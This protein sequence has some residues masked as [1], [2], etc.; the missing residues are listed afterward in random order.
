ME[1]FLI[2]YEKSKTQNP[3]NR[4]ISRKERKEKMINSLKDPNNPYSNVWTN[5]ILKINY[6]VSME[7]KGF[8]NGI[9]LFRIKK[10]KEEPKI[11]P[12]YNMTQSKYGRF[13]DLNDNIYKE[14]TNQKEKKKK[15]NN[16]KFDI[17]FNHFDKNEKKK[18]SNKL[19]ENI[20]ENE[21]EKKNYNPNTVS[22]FS[23]YDGKYDVRN[24]KDYEQIKKSIEERNNQTVVQKVVKK[25]DEINENEED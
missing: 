22:L 24:E 7:V 20:K 6:N 3:K 23:N 25:L 8:Q 4:K 2:Q 16:I 15:D 19:N 1:T 21:E 12:L 5:R 18:N 9:P 17:L 11:K 13:G 10:L 14:K